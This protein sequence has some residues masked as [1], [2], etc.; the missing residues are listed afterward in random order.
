[1]LSNAASHQKNYTVFARRVWTQVLN[2]CSNFCYS[3]RHFCRTKCSCLGR[4][5]Q[6]FRTTTDLSNDLGI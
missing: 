1:M 2:I 6:S 5:D 3:Q 4:F